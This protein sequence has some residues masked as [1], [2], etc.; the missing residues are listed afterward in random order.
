MNFELDNSQIKKRN[1]HVVVKSNT[2]VS[3]DTSSVR[4]EFW[5]EEGSEMKQRLL[6]NKNVK[7]LN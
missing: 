4:I 1:D 3:K 6:Q 2:N 7:V 5:F